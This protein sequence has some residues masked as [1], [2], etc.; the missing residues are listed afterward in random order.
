MAPKQL[1]KRTALQHVMSSRI[2]SL[3][4]QLLLQRMISIETQSIGGLTKAIKVTTT[5]SIYTL[6]TIYSVLLWLHSASESLARR[7]GP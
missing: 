5:R 7:E 1:L 2:L 4:A 3:V 6:L